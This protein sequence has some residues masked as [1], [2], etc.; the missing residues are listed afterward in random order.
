[1]KRFCTLVAGAAALLI[2]SLS[3]PSLGAADTSG[4]AGSLPSLRQ[5]RPVTYSVVI[6]GRLVRFN[7]YLWLNFMQPT[8]PP[9]DPSMS[10]TVTASTSHRLGLPAGMNISSIRVTQGRAVWT[11]DLQHQGV[12][13]APGTII[14]TA[15]GGPLWNVGSKVNVEIRYTLNN[16]VRRITLKNVVIDSAF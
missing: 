9:N 3:I 1:M 14:R 16:S 7:V 5:S 15:S 12:A 6:N 11:T 10:A 4:T 13:D 8:V 2:G